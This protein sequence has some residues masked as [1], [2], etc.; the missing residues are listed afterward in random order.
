VLVEK[1]ATIVMVKEK[2]IA[3]LATDQERMT[4][5]SALT[6][7]ETVKSLASIV[8]AKE[9]EN[10]IRVVVKEPENVVSAVEMEALN[11]KDVT[12]IEM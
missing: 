10:V 7:E 4:M 9:A 12:E 6:V 5:K 11:V 3:L 8:L 2:V 1:I